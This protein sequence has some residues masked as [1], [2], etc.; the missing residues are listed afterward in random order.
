VGVITM[1]PVE[2]FDGFATPDPLEVADYIR[3]LKDTQA[4][5]DWNS[6]TIVIE[7][8]IGGGPRDAAI[9]HTIQVLGFLRLWAIYSGYTVEV[10]VPQARK[11]FVNQA[12]QISQQRDKD[13]R[14]VNDATAHALGL[15][16]EIQRREAKERRG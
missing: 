13:S 15:A 3:D 5:R 4:D 12:Y 2:F 10:R 1:P 8:F 16:W 9:V 14:H 11:A 6:L 7:D